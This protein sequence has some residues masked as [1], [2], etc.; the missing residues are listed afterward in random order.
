MEYFMNYSIAIWIAIAT[1]IVTS[2][3]IAIA[4]AIAVALALA[5]ERSCNRDRMCHCDRN[6]NLNAM[7]C[8]RM[9]V[10]CH[11]LLRFPCVIAQAISGQLRAGL[12]SAINSAMCD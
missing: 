6:R 2:I 3:A 11:W 1:A 7:S 10:L 12:D 5:N 8:A 9:R 4:V